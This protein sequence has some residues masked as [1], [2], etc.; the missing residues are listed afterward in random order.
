MVAP[1]SV[2]YDYLAVPWEHPDF[3]AHGRD[4]TDPAPLSTSKYSSG[5]AQ[6]PAGGTTGSD[7]VT[8]AGAVGVPVAGL[9]RGRARRSYQH[10][11]L[12]G[13]GHVPRFA[14]RGQ[15]RLRAR[16]D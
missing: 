2:T 5:A 15:R 12:P 10:G 14:G 4:D 3:E 1:G 11:H 16:R 9:R 13:H 8:I 7:A 6:D